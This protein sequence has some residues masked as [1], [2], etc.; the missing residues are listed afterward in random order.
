MANL[1]K[2]QTV[3]GF[4]S[5]RTIEK[6]IPEIEILVDNFSGQNWNTTTQ[7]NFF[8]VLFASEFYEGKTR[9]Q[10]VPLA[11]RDRITRAP[12]ALGFVN[13]KPTIEITEAGKYLLS[14]KRTHEVIARQLLKFQLP[15]PYHKT[16]IDRNFNV[17]PYLELLRLV[18]VIGNISKTEIA[19][20]FVQI[21]NYNKFDSIVEKILE[22][23]NDYKANTGNK[24]E[25]IKSIFAREIKIIYKEDIAKND[26]KGREDNDSTLDE[27]IDRK[28][29][30]HYDYADAFIRY[31]RATELTTFDK[32]FRII[33]SKI[34]QKEVDFILNNTQREAIVFRNE[35]EFKAYLFNPF[36]IEL[37]TDKKENVVN[38]L[39]L[40]EVKYDENLNVESLKDVLEEAEKNKHESNIKLTEQGLKHYKEFGDI[41]NT[42]TQIEKKIVPDAPLYLEWN[43]WR[44]MVMI[45]YAKK[46]QGNFKLDLE[47][48]PLNTAGARLPDIYIEYENFVMIVEVTMSSGQK[49]YDMEGEPVARHFGRAKSETTKPVYCL[50][51]APKISEG[52]LAHFFVL[53]KSAPKFYGGKTSIVPMNLGTFIKFIGTAKEKEFNNDL[54][55]KNYFDNILSINRGS[56]DET[57]WMSHIE[58]SVNSWV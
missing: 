32:N 19:L 20:F 52:T 21:T 10:N 8:N 41:L 46:V 11:A 29:A 34:R 18:N 48:T 1:S 42:F 2:T 57:E 27:F 6:I 9:P 31:L 12:K 14:G 5:P 49:Q 38:Q 37:L 15:S 13:L 16:P 33:I 51:V 56:E 26:F 28:E 24:K 4:T 54:Q 30:N 7:T 17:R 25:F 44:S 53:N 22:Y 3:F 43:V 36:T 58:T 45:N 47:G 55:L 39:Q 50:F 23:R 35:D 40:L